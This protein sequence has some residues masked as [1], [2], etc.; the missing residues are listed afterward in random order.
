MR[1]LMSWLKFFKEVVAMPEI[2]ENLRWSLW[3]KFLKKMVAM[4]EIKI[5][6]KKLIA[7]AE[8]PKKCGRYG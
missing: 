1:F 2:H 4:A 6:L 3:L 5:F 7:M 8:I